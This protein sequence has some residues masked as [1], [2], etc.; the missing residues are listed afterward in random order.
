MWDD[1]AREYAANIE[2]DSIVYSAAAA[3]WVD[4]GREGAADP[5]LREAVLYHTQAVD[6]VWRHAASTKEIAT[7][8]AHIFYTDQGRGI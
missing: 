5:R 4:S 7:I 3:A 1:R 2:L 6:P 8:G